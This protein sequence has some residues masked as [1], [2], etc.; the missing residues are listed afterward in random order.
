[1]TRRLW[2]R[3]FHCLSS[4]V[5][6]RQA[7]RASTFRP[8]LESLEELVLLSGITILPT[9]TRGIHTLASP[10]GSPAGLSPAQVRH[11]YGFDQIT[12]QG[13][14]VAGT[15]AGQTVAIVDAYDDPSIATDLSVFDSQYGLAAPTFVKVGI[16]ASGAASTSQFPTADAGWAGEIELDVEWVHAVAPGAKILLVEANSASDTDLLN[17]VDYARQQSGVVAVSMSWGSGEFSGEQNYD[18]HFTTPAG[19]VGVTFFGSSGDDGSPSLWPALSTHVVGVG[20]TSL[21]VDASGNYLGETGWSGSGGSL[22]SYV[23][24]PSYQTGLTIHNGSS[25]LFQRRQAGRP[26]RGLRRRPQLGRG[27]LR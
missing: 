12:F 15:G 21:S 2:Q 26:G 8:R 1:M 24:Q 10:L 7:K 18:S 13:G 9:H 5:Y 6:R 4:N 19:H 20:G 16:N 27:R 23:S 3:L 14:A 17:A 25:T 11:A 22:S